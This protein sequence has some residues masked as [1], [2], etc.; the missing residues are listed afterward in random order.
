MELMTSKMRKEEEET[1][2]EKK[3][4]IARKQSKK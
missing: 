3:G 1:G 2:H 4:G